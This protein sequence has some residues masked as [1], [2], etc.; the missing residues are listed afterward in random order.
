MVTVGAFVLWMA[1]WGVLAAPAQP[2]GVRLWRRR[3]LRAAAV[4]GFV[5]LGFVAYHAWRGVRDYRLL[6]WKHT[7]KDTAE[8][9][10][11]ALEYGAAAW[12]GIL[13]L[14]AAAEL[15]SVAA[16]RGRA[17]P[18]LGV[19]VLS[20]PFLAS[21]LAPKKEPMGFLPHP[22]VPESLEW[23]GALCLWGMIFGGFACI[24][25]MAR[26]AKGSGDPEAA[27]RARRFGLRAGLTVTGLT[28][29][30]VHLLSIHV[31]M[32]R[33]LLGPR[34]MTTLWADLT[35]MVTGNWVLLGGL[36]LGLGAAGMAGF[37]RSGDE[38][39]P[40]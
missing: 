2:D 21:L 36:S 24:L 26:M 20:V 5:A 31:L 27:A 3:C 35:G 11:P 1:V 9:A 18:L 25:A 38:N 40:P 14:A 23:V 29:V 30:A 22:P 6:G 4:L 17:R 34:L 8:W 32:Q 33:T 13:V 12:I 39:P 7:P 37:G 15:A 10:I 16:K 28:V 19:L